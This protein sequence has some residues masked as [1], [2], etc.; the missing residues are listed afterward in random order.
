MTPS[1]YKAAIMLQR[2]EWIRY[3]LHRCMKKQGVVVL[4]REKVLSVVPGTELSKQA[5]RL[6]NSFGYQVQYRMF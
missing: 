2:Q 6:T 1:E 4:A 3:N 5:E